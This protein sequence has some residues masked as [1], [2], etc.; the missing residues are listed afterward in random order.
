MNSEQS[1]LIEDVF[2]HL[3]LPPKLPRKFDG[4]NAALTE[5][6]GKRLHESLAILRFVGNP[7]IWDALD[8]SLRATRDVNQ[9]LLAGDDLRDGFRAV[10]ESPIWLTLHVAQQNAA[11]LIHRDASGEN[12]I[13]ES[14]QVSAPVRDVLN[15]NH[16]LAC[17]FPGRAVEVPLHIFND[18]SFQE[19][20]AD[21]LEQSSTE[22]FDQFAARASKGGESVVETRDC[23]NPALVNDMLMS[24]L[25]G[26]GK[27]TTVRQIRKRVRDDVVLDSSEVPWRRSPYW[28]VLRVAA[29]RHLTNMFEDERNGRVC[30]K[31]LICVVLGYL[32][33]ECVGSLDPE[34]TLILQAKLCRRLAKLESEQKA[35][36]GTLCELYGSLFS[37]TKTFFEFTIDAVERDV[38]A[39]WEKHKTSIIRHIPL[40][41]G[42]VSRNDLVLKLP[43]SGPYLRSLLSNGSSIM[44]GRVQ[45]DVPSLQEGTISQVNQLTSRYTELIDHKAQTRVSVERLLSCPEEACIELSSSLDEPLPPETV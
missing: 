35:T 42:R 33:R 28:L 40:L 17:D 31:F 11:L 37:A 7:A 16:A 19:N 1:S 25:E 45:R 4:N 2:H 8:A 27:P 43:Q 18:A 39:Q 23:P 24:L 41:P 29:G 12:V 36:S 20:L 9:G 15:A 10:I 34:M 21:F 22:A 32:L 13:F 30:Y 26:L 3:V 44:N 14:F 38:G 5:N 6:L